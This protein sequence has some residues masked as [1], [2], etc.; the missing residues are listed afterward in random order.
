[1]ERY[2]N[3]ENKKIL[4]LIENEKMEDELRKQILNIYIQS[5]RSEENH[6]RRHK[7]KEISIDQNNEISAKIIADISAKKDDLH[8]Q[9]LKKIETKEL[10]E[11]IHQLD[12]V[13]QKFIWLFFYCDESTRVIAKE[14]NM[15]QT[16][17]IRMKKKIIAKLRIIMNFND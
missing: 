7:N 17:V 3:D 4:E 14:M 16:Q 5:F 12:K 6:E 13:E 11:A 10:Y 1:M 9:I 8:L 15:H 2:L